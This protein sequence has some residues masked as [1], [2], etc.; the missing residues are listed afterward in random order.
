MERVVTVTGKEVESPTNVRTRIGIS[1]GSLVDFAGGFPETTGKVLAGGPMMGKALANLDVP[2]VKGM[3]GILLIPSNESQLLESMNCIRCAKCVDVCPMGLNPA[4]LMN[5]TGFEDW[6][7]AEKTASS[8]V[9][10]AEHVVMFVRQTD[11]C[12]ITFVGERA[13]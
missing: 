13:K 2:V 9:S 11:R 12:S 1:V 4:F 5:F 3:A 8:I 7:K 6:G 10:N